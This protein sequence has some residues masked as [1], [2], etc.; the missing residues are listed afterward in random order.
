MKYFDDHPFWFRLLF[1]V[2]AAYLL[3]LAALNLHRFASFQTDE[4]VFET[5][6][7]RLYVIKSF[8]AQLAGRESRKY[9]AHTEAEPDSILV[10]DLLLALNGQRYDSLQQVRQQLATLGAEAVFELYVKRTKTND[11]LEFRINKSAWP[12]SSLRQAPSGVQIISVVPGGASDRAGMRVGDLILRINGQG[13]RNAFEAD[14]IMRR[15]EANRAI[16][17]QI[18]RDN[19]LLTLHVTLA[20]FSADVYVFFGFFAGLVFWGVAM[21]LA[22]SRPYLQAARLVALALLAFSFP[23]M[24]IY[25]RQVAIDGLALLIRLTIPATVFAGLTLLFHSNAYF[26]KARPELLQRPWTL[27]VPYMIAGFFYVMLLLGVTHRGV[28]ILAGATLLSLYALVMGLVFHKKCSA[29]YKKLNRILKW[30]CIIAAML[31]L[32]SGLGSL[33]GQPH[34]GLV[35]LPLALIPLA[36]LYT[37]GRYHLLDL[38]L[39][40]R[41]NAQFLIVSWACGLLLFGGFM[42]ALWK[43]PQL[44][45]S[46][47]NVRVSGSHIE[48]LDEPLP[49]E[50]RAVFEKVVLMIFAIG[51]VYVFRRG[52]RGVQLFLARKFYR[53]GY[54]Y[55]RAVNELSEVMATKLGMLDLAKGISRKLADHIQLKRVGV[56]FFRDQKESSCQEA[57][58]FEQEKWREFCIAIDRPLIDTLQKFRSESRFSTEYLPPAL[59]ERFHEHGFAH[60]LPIR[61][62]EK[63]VGALL[64]G[65]KLSEAGFHE[66]DLHYLAAVA[67]QAS[68]AIE[69]AFLYEELAEK[70]RMKHELEIA[71]RIQLA[72]LPQITP[73]IPGLDIA[74]ISIPALEVGGDYFDYLN[75]RPD[76]ITVIVGDVS[77]KGTSAALYMSKVQGILRSLHDFGLSPR[78]LFIRA[79]HLL[80]EA[81]DR[82]SFVTSIG[83][84]FDAS[85]KQ[86]RLARAG[87]LPL[88]Y[89]QA[90]TGRIELI[91]PKGLGLGL[92]DDRLFA[93]ELEERSLSYETGDVFLFATD[94]VTEAQGKHG[95]EFGEESLSEILSKSSAESAHGIRDHVITAVKSFVNGEYQHDDLTLVVVKAV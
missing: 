79:N 84:C 38:N 26:P 91:T 48:L 93:A 39:R 55:R 76:E 47:P 75:G 20:R 54:D 37:I 94:G 59:K 30:T 16:A 73:R 33:Q 49:P 8:P 5:S 68:L 32:L 35:M 6:P 9:A 70:E 89:Y 40:V 77:G 65:E 87:H 67:K 4:N 61:F 78:E 92:D 53:T 86:L 83:A 85:A 14:R 71:R 72:S 27:A 18:L 74:G 42:F 50:Q 2:A 62:K 44:P 22:M 82:N 63:L 10:G 34:L 11:R 58:G 45:I 41:R 46:A 29:E 24:V 31:A 19:Q 1:G 57:Y 15:A 66:E 69:N 43:L 3:I 95:N 36:Y 52:H 90:R 13:F 7:S 56:L 28:P 25:E 12:D 51:L 88:F 17:Y 81:L 64:I 23:I 21:F 80:R 60:I